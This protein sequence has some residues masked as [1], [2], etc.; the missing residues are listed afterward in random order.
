M[1]QLVS[2][3]STELCKNPSL[4]AILIKKKF[5]PTDREKDSEHLTMTMVRQNK[6]AS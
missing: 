4:S 6:K 3:Q 5:L 1:N 2:Y